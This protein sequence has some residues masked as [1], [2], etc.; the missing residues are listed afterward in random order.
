MRALDRLIAIRGRRSFFIQRQPRRHNPFSRTPTP[1]AAPQ[2]DHPLPPQ[3]E[4][5]PLRPSLAGA[6]L[7]IF[8]FH[9][10]CRI[11]VG[12]GE[13]IISS[14]CAGFRHPVRPALFLPF[15]YSA[16]LR[17]CA[18]LSHRNGRSS[19]EPLHPGL[20]APSPHS[21]IGR[22]FYWPSDFTLCPPW[23]QT[24]RAAGALRA[25]SSR[26][27]R[28]ADAS[29]GTSPADCPVSRTPLFRSGEAGLRT[30]DR[31]VGR[32]P[33]KQP[34]APGVRPTPTRGTA[35]RYPASCGLDGADKSTSEDADHKRPKDGLV[36]LL[37]PR[38]PSLIHSRRPPSE[39]SGVYLC[40][41]THSAQAPSPR[42][43]APSCSPRLCRSTA[44]PHRPSVS[45]SADP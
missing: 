26:P 5:P 30:A 37:F 2:T 44:A 24:Y 31:R 34:A 12:A 17:A 15:L 19:L 6:T 16:H 22:G 20:Q 36:S 4:N 14:T 29:R 38:Y 11:T 27:R 33:N 39:T 3:G 10:P 25:G 32:L 18:C 1:V 41:L 23:I 35:G 13:H 28:C 8:F 21:P 7:P 40:P 45:P 43:E 9:L 42:F